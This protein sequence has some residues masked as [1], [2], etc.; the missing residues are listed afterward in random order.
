MPE[1]RGHF[2]VNLTWEPRG[3][4]TNEPPGVGFLWH[5]YLNAMPRGR[6]VAQH[7]TDFYLVKLRQGPAGFLFFLDDGQQCV[8]NPHDARQREWLDESHATWA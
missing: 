5:Q 2:W 6:Q 1:P 4:A 8:I 7:V 3:H